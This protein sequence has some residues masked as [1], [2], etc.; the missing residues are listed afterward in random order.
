MKQIW[1]VTP[2]VFLLGCNPL[3]DVDIPDQPPGEEVETPDFVPRQKI[4]LTTSVDDSQ[5]E[6]TEEDVE[7]RV[8]ALQQRA[9]Q[10]RDASLE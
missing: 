6:E 10:L 1:A 8:S 9:E 5:R 3:P 4:A 2:A 7:A